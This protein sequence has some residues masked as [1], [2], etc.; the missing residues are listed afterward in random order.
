MSLLLII[1]KSMAIGILGSIP[2]GPIVM[3]SVQSSISCGQRA[4]MRCA[5]GAILSDTVFAAMALFAVSITS[6]LLQKYSS[7]IQICGGVIIAMIG[8]LMLLKKGDPKRRKR[9]RYHSMADAAKSLVMGFSNPASFFWVLGA[10]TASG[11][12]SENISVAESFCVV[13]GLFAGCLLYWLLYTHFAAKKEDS[14]SV[15]TLKRISKVFGA[16]IIA[17]GFFFIIFGIIK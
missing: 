10:L 4:G 1:L 17:F 15:P 16:A 7:A 9:S 3:L 8:V 14:F 2:V 11:M 5:L 12:G 6:D 13:F